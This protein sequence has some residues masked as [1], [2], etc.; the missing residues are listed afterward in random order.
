V[1]LTFVFF[2][3]IGGKFMERKINDSFL[4][5]SVNSKNVKMDNLGSLRKEGG[6]T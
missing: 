3:K 6:A 2:L 5:H 4:D 1:L